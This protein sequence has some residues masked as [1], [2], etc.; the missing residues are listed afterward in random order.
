[1]ARRARLFR[2]DVPLHLIQRGHNRDVCFSAEVDRLVYLN[3]LKECADKAACAIHAYVLM[4]NHVHLLLSPSAPESGARMMKALGQ[5]YVQYFNRRYERSGTL[6]EGR[7]RSCIVENEYYFLTCQRYI[8][9][10][11]VRAAIVSHPGAYSWSSYRA[12]AEGIPNALV[13]PHDLYRRLA[14]EPTDRQA[15]YRELF[16]NEIDS[17]ILTLL[18]RA[19]NGNSTIADG[20]VIDRYAAMLGSSAQRKQKISVGAVTSGK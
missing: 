4:T 9:L 19:T 2:S 15:A 17:D 18:R 13:T 12:N 5:R 20:L 14:H 10:N 8:E 16:A 11:P 7:Y 1:M 3:M 6:W